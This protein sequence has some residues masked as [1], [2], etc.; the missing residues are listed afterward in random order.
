MFG[1]KTAPAQFCRAVTELLEPVRHL[2]VESY[3]DDIS[4][5]HEEW[6]HHLHA[7]KKGLETM[8]LAGLRFNLRKTEFCK[9]E[10]LVLGYLVTDEGILPNPTKHQL[11]RDWPVPQ[12]IKL[13]N[14]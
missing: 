4:L 14:K 1:L 13:C 5:L 2:G 10:L 12:T 7:I 9:K 3:F 6:H 8:G 11:L